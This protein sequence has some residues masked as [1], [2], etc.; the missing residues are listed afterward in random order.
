MLH[1]SYYELLKA[2]QCDSCPSL[3]LVSIKWGKYVGDDVDH[4]DDDRSSK[5]EFLIFKPLNFCHQNF[6]CAVMLCGAISKALLL[7]Y[8]KHLIP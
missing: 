6:V 8:M 5:F 7:L 2:G 4:D 1:Q 3:L